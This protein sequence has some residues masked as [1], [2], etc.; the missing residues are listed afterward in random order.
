MMRSLLLWAVTWIYM[1]AGAAL[2]LPWAVVTGRLGFAYT[3]GR[4]GARLLLALAGV[5]VVVEG[6]TNAAGPAPIFM[7][8]H[9]SNL[10]PPVLLAHL[11]GNLA[12]LAKKELFSVPV[13]GTVL[14]AGQLFPVDR[15]DR[16]AARASITLAAAGVR[17]GRPL[18]IFPEGTR[19]RTGELLP[20]KKGAFYLVE[21]AQ[22]PVVP[23]TITGSGT[24]MPPG[25]WRIRSGVVRVQIH[26]PVWP[27]E[28]QSSP[29]PRAACAALVRERMQ[30]PSAS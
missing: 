1:L 2:C 5:R 13:L 19:T 10:D 14:R 15:T 22:A 24:L 18:L 8:N 9:Q 7:A 25:S 26:P 29:D 16:N 20:F 17:A 11:P 3:V 4:G 23:I 27:R 21:Q 12:F 28:W 30:A 6:E